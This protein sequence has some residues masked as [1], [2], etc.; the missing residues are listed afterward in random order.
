MKAK[1]KNPLKIFIS[2]SHNDRPHA[3]RLAS[4]LKS[5][6]AEVYVD[7]KATKPGD[8][9]PR[10]IEKALEWCDTL[11][12]LWTMEA[13]ESHWV[14]REWHYALNKR[15]RVIPCLVDGT[16][17]SPL[18]STTQYFDFREIGAGMS[19]LFDALALTPTGLATSA[20]REEWPFIA[21]S[22]NLW[23]VNKK[24]ATWVGIAAAVVTIITGIVKLQESIFPI[25][26]ESAIFLGKVIDQSG[27]DVG[28]LHIQNFRIWPVCQNLPGRR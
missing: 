16:E 5:A 13:Q 25:I 6:G 15:K 1:R 8:S 24:I 7:Y 27:N 2:Y 21:K 4:E 9:F 23:S 11:I 18:L 10:R 17:L 26:P 14:E 22:K 3:K 19:Q 12:L 20:E 28:V